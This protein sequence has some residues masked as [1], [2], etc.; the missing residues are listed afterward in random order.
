[1]NIHKLIHANHTTHK[2]FIDWVKGHSGVIGNEEA[3]AAAN[4]GARMHKAPDYSQFSISYVKHK[5]HTEHHAIWQARYESSPQGSHT[6]TLL[7]KLNDIKELNKCTQTNFQLTQILTGHGY[8]KTY[9]HRFK[10]APD[11]T[12]PC[13]GTSSQTVEHLLKNC[14]VFAAKRHS[15][16]ETCHEVQ[17]SPYNLPEML[18]KK[19]AINSFTSFCQTI[20]NNIKKINENN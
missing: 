3:D 13:D 1:M 10:I 8:H 17:V 7:P 12:C 2:I 5:I 15:H 14:Q 11:D 6:K 9:L 19:A 16:E 20:I 4:S 18:K